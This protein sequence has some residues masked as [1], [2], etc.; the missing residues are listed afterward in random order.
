MHF[1]LSVREN[2]TIIFLLFR[3]RQLKVFNECFS[4]SI[5]NAYKKQ[6]FLNQ[7]HSLK[8][9]VFPEEN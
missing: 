8:L 4:E 1:F 2:V 6:L 7:N 5:E 9:F 3:L